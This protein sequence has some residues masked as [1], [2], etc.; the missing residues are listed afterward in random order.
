ML[1]ASLL[2]ACAAT[3]VPNQNAV[4]KMSVREARNVFLKYMAAARMNY[5]P[6]ITVFSAETVRS[7]AVQAPNITLVTE[8]GTHVFPFKDLQPAVLG[9]EQGIIDLQKGGRII[10]SD[11]GISGWHAADSIRVA[12]ALLVLKNSGLSAKDDEAQFQEVARNYR[13][14]NPKPLLPENARR[15]VVQAEAAT[16]AN[17][18]AGAADLYAQALEI[19][20]WWPEGHYNRA[21]MLAGL[22]DFAAAIDEMKRYL[23]LAPEAPNA[24]AAQDKIYVWERN[25]SK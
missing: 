4:A 8:Q 3:Y 19:A 16:D 17:D 22:K 23:A 1:A 20:P 24:R 25:V 18:F 21:I 6:G 2:C 13:A 15:F 5:W 10:P 14:S 12:D 7:V 11:G 9:G